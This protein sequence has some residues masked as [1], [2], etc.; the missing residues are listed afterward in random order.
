MGSC[1]NIPG[2]ILPKPKIPA[3]CSHPGLSGREQSM[4]SLL[5][6]I[7]RPS[8]EPL[9][10][11]ETAW[12]HVIETTNYGTI[13]VVVSRG[14]VLLPFSCSP[15]TGVPVGSSVDSFVGESQSSLVL[16]VGADKNYHSPK[17]GDWLYVSLVENNAF[18]PW[19]SLVL[20]A[21]QQLTPGLR[22]YSLA[23][24]ADNGLELSGEF[25]RDADVWIKCQLT[26]CRLQNHLVWI[27]AEIHG[28]YKNAVVPAP[29]LQ[30][31]RSPGRSRD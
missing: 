7:G 26:G 30:N 14:R 29:E 25:I 5:W 31:P 8:R 2:W 15:P 12:H 22:A 19:V 9:A 6:E 11:A 24:L 13:A 28:A 3:I 17:P 20:R 10:L 1:T 23:L 16:C 18:D 21:V 27:H 4:F